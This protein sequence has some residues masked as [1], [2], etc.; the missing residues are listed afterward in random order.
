MSLA[1]K[2][3]KKRQ[4]LKGEAVEQDAE[5]MRAHMMSRREK[6]EEKGSSLAD[7]IR[8][9]ADDKEADDDDEDEEDEIDDEELAAAI[10]EAKT[11]YEDLITRVQMTT[12][13]REV[14]AL[15]NDIETLPESID[16]VRSRG[17][18]FRSYLESKIE[19]MA[20]QWDAV[21]DRIEQW[22]DEEAD[23]LDDE[24]ADAEKAYRRLK[25]RATESRL[26]TLNGYLDELESQ[27][28]ASEE[29]IQALYE[30]VQREVSTTTSQ[31]SK[32]NKQLDWLE[33]SDIEL[34]ATE[35]LFMA[36]EAEWDDDRDKPEGYIFVTDQRILFEQSEKKGGMLGFG[37]K[38]VKEILWEVPHDSVEQVV[39]ENRG[40]M[41]GNDMMILKLGS[42]AP[43]PEIVCEIKG[44]I[45][46]EYWAQQVNRAAKGYITQESAIEP[47]PE[48]I[49]R[50]QNA[51]TACPNCG[52]VLPKITAGDTDVTCKYCGNVIR[53]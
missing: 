18:K 43:Y 35:G 23:E 31:L 30:E 49:E 40:M 6:A 53:I 16:R 13:I 3:R 41:G 19:V 17:Y 15:G 4:A 39:P 22:L 12:I 5:D 44:G 10:E 28:E 33:G 26:E 51:P 29:K 42:G 27:L 50:L 32:V 21:N 7:R 46:A 34:G 11:R 38:Q 1:D 8:S 36:A 20:E 14:S 52:G 47:D 48:L 9:K 45:E 25:R 24:L 37:G 2:M